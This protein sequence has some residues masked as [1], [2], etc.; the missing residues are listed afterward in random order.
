[1]NSI[2]T[3]LLERYRPAAAVL[4]ELPRDAALYAAASEAALLEVN[5]LFAVSQV[6]LRGGGAFIPVRSLTGLHPSSGRRGWR[7]EPALERRSSSSSRPPG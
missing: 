6:A 2:D 1:M 7:S 5:Q 4:A 3:E